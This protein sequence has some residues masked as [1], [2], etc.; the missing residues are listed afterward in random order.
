MTHYIGAFT[1]EMGDA[2]PVHTTTTHHARCRL[3][4]GH[5]SDWHADGTTTARREYVLQRPAAVVAVCY[6][7]VV[8]YCCVPFDFLDWRG[9]L[10]VPRNDV[11]TAA[12]VNETHASSGAVGGG[13]G[14]IFHSR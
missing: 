9:R 6:I 13:E 1:C 12:A 2:R 8:C 3:D 10:C 7:G 5:Q 14:V 11:Y 4:N